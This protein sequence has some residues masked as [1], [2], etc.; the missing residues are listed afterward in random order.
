[1]S[2]REVKLAHL[3]KTEAWV[4]IYSSGLCKVYL[5]FPLAHVVDDL[6]RTKY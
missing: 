6:N 4:Y 1:M 2:L 5:G 3:T